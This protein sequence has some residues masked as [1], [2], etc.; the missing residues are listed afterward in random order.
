MTDFTPFRT[1]CPRWQVES[2]CS[3]ASKNLLRSSVSVG[4]A[5]A[6][7]GSGLQQVET[8]QQQ[9]TSGVYVIAGTGMGHNIGMSQWGAY[10]MAQKGFTAEEII[11]FY[12]T[13][14]TVDYYD[15]N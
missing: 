14:V 5:Y 2:S 9:D 11:R 8:Q 6:I 3:S 1:I 12:Y 15:P 13:G 10:A 7:T 4:G